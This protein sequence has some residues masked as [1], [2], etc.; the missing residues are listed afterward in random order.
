MNTFLTRRF[1]AFDRVC[2]EHPSYL[3]VTSFRVEFGGQSL[4]GSSFDS[5]SHS[6]ID[7]GWRYEGR[8]AAAK[9]SL[10]EWL[11][12]NAC[13]L[14]H[15]R[16]I[17][18][19]A[20][21]LMLVAGAVHGTELV[22]INAAGSGAA[23]G[24]SVLSSGV[25]A[26]HYIVF[27]STATDLVA[28]V[29]D[30]TFGA[31][32][33]RRDLRTGAT[34][35]VSVTPDGSS[36]GNSE[37]DGAQISDDGRWVA[38]RSFATNLT[39]E[40]DSNGN[41]DVFLRDMLTGTT[42]RLS[43]N[44]SGTDSGNGSSSLEAISADGRI[45]VFQS[46][47]SDLTGLNDLNAESDLFAYDR[48]T[49]L[50]QVITI[51][52]AGTATGNGDTN[53]D[54][55]VTPDGRHVAFSSSATDL[56]LR[57]DDN[58]IFDV[59]RR[60]LVTGTTV[61]VSVNA[62]GVAGANGESYS[63]SDCIS[64]DGRFVLFESSGN[65]LSP[66]DTN[67]HSDVYLRDLVNQ[68]TELVSVNAAMTAAGTGRSNALGLSRDGRYVV[69]ASRASDLVAQA[70]S[71]NEIYWRDRISAR[72]RLVSHDLAGAGGGG[73]TYEAVIAPD[74]SQVV[75]MSTGSGFVAA[76]DTN[77]ATDLFQWDARSEVVALISHSQAGNTT[78]NARS[79]FARIVADGNVAFY[80]LASNLVNN[81]TN[82]TSDV[83][84]YR[85]HVFSDSLE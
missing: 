47:A 16:S 36:T 80:S 56:V 54:V 41:G 52:R 83:F 43:T 67:A 72:T 44:A 6:A 42:Q 50:R 61:R 32:V 40:P 39:A 76:S 17:S 57:L 35:L 73:D 74:G 30:A 8:R 58:E 7:M 78:G 3:H 21:A 82:G 64:N 59:F 10:R 53:G 81:D 79:A 29:N 45:V 34:H 27:R 12:M 70:T 37:S 11:R 62:E 68:S 77:N 84:V 75:F 49:G 38:F 85:T 19:I 71:V 63:R 1:F 9:P 25:S 2:E 4:G 5:T 69:F 22:S 55:C 26:G 18:R 65:D 31:D 51:N 48:V 13:T 66:L 20:A 60:D 14:L 33:F 28:G 23:N 24:G 15:A 46:N